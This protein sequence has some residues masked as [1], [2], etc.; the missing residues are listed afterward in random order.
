M[1]FS[2]DQ[3]LNLLEMKVL[4][5]QERGRNNYNNREGCQLFYLSRLWK[6]YL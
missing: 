6:N 2:V 1:K 5:F 4:D 3:I